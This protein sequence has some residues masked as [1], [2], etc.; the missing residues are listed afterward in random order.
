MKQILRVIIAAGWLCIC[1]G[2]PVQ[3]ADAPYDLVLRN[4]RIV[5]GTGSPWYRGDVAIRGDPIARIA[6]SI[7]G[8]GRAHHRR[9][10]PRRRAGLHRSS[11]PTRAAASFSVPTADNYM[12]Q[13]VT[14]I[15]EGPDGGSPVPLEPFL[16]KL[17][18]M[19]KSLNIGSVHRTG[20]GA[21]AVIGTGEPH[22]DCRRDSNDARARARTACATARSA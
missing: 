18:A 1:V 20:L 17:A 2:V 14:T 8:P 3:A 10:R 15:I 16:D 22:G 6:P 12:R 13:G 5:D 7:D 11:T 21:A 9:R 4:G 19:P